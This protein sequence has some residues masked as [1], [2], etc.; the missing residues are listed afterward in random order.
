M[1][2]LKAESE[3]IF[4]NIPG[5]DADHGPSNLVEDQFELFVI[6]KLGKAN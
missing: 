1:N 2:L 4:R 6:E 5:N 3:W